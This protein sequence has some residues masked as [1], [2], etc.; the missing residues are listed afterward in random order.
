VTGG[1]VDFYEQRTDDV[2]V[3]FQGATGEKW[4]FEPLQ[5]SAGPLASRVGIV[6]LPD[7]AIYSCRHAAS[8]HVRESHS[9]DG[10]FLTFL[11][12]ASGP[13]KWYGR[14]LEPDLALLFYPDHEQDYVL[15]CHATALGFMI[16]RPLL[17]D[18]GW[19]TGPVPLRKISTAGIHSLTACTGQLFRL[20]RQGEMV[21]EGGAQI[22]QERLM[23]GLDELIKPSLQDAV[24]TKRH[25]PHPGRYFRLIEK[26]RRYMAEHDPAQKLDIGCMAGH[27]GA[28]P[29]TLYRAFTRYL[30]IGPYEY[31]TLLR[32]HTFRRMIRDGDRCHGAITAAASRAGFLHL[33]RFAKLYQRHYGELPRESLQR[34]S[35]NR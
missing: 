21:D 11:L 3:L 19:S 13:A 24:V 31:F 5:L 20:V 2:E 23:V 10:I 17:Q 8:L 35:W 18:M 33:G 32:F 29:R 34:W 6:R 7:M 14:E 22:L 25:N 26:A 4:D 27:L 16:R 1:A 30:G 28:S 12:D 15:P 9:E